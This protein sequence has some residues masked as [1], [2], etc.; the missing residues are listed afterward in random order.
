MIGID[1]FLAPLFAGYL[2][3][4]ASAC[5]YAINPQVNVVS[6]TDRIQYDFSKSHKDL[7]NF[8]IDTL[9]PY[10]R[11]VHTT[12]GGLMSGDISVKSKMKVSWQQATVRGQDGRDQ[13][14][15]VDQ[16]DIGLRIDPVVYIA[17]EYPRNSCRHKAVMEHEMKHIAA[18]RKIIA[19]YSGLIRQQVIYD[20]KRLGAVGPLSKGELASYQT[21]MGDFIEKSIAGIS[22]KMYAERNQEQQ[23]IDNLKEYERVQSK[24]SDF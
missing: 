22:E 13:C 18:D 14:I 9:S 4:A 8:H 24:C 17:S 10:D 5:N 20:I 11:G 15:W 1:L 7:Q 23:K 3:V 16:V 19:K 21:K 6:T 2:N 12:V